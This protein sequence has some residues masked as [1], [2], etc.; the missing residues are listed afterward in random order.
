MNGWQEIHQV[1]PLGLE[2]GWGW[3]GQRMGPEGGQGSGTLVQGSRAAGAGVLPG[4]GGGS[5]VVQEEA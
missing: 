3:H 4:D 1:L 2:G 5:S